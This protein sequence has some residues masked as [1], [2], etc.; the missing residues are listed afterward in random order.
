MKTYLGT[1]A[2]LCLFILGCKE[3]DK[4]SPQ[5]PD[6]GTIYIGQ[7]K[8]PGYIALTIAKDQK[9]F[10]EVGL[11][12]E[13][14][15]VD[16]NQELNQAYTAG[17]YH[18]R[19]NLLVDAIQQSVLGVDHRVIFAFDYSNGSDAIV[20]DPTIETPSD[21]VGKRVSFE[22]E[23]IGEF[24]LLYVLDQFGFSINDI[25]PVDASAKDGATLL[26]NGEVDAAVTYE[27]F[28]SQLL[29]K[30]EHHNLFSSSEAPGLIT[31]VMT[32]RIDF[33][34]NYPEATLKFCKA[35]FK[36]LEILFNEPD[37]AHKILAREWNLTPLEIQTQ[38][39][40]IQMLD[41]RLNKTAFSVGS[42]SNSIY[43]NA[44]LMHELVSKSKDWENTFQHAEIIESTF[45]R[46]ME[47]ELHNPL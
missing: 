41:L 13:I 6:P 29:D 47:T 43:S 33:L 1:L 46:R 32:F 30:G 17:K 5:E 4:T 10:E 39:E 11:D 26:E 7:V 22:K 9:L 23:T 16:S 42:A 40:G 35:Y 14:E 25:I 24:F 28:L 31:D 44:R 12:V 37:K 15:T 20:S 8:W 3:P 19:T 2:L 27:P 21:L 45:L 36:A 18:G 34:E 38:L